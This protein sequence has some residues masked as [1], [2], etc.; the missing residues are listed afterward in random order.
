MSPRSSPFTLRTQHGCVHGRNC[1][2]N[3][4]GNQQ[5][6]QTF[7]RQIGIANQKPEPI[8]SNTYNAAQGFAQSTRSLLAAICCF[9]QTDS[10]ITNGIIQTARTNL[11]GQL[12]KVILNI[13]EY[14]AERIHLLGHGSGKLD[15]SNLTQVTL[16]PEASPEDFEQAKKDVESK[17]GKVT[18]EFKLIK[19]FTYVSTSA[20]EPLFITAS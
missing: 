18:H 10:N 19:G 2:T 8:S 5:C 3:R 12:R 7:N 14:P 11:T 20:P 6:C 4:S 15:I 17:G 13:A 9:F 16:K 1:T